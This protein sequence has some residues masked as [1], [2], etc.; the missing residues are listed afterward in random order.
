MHTIRQ[1]SA[2]IRRVFALFAIGRWFLTGFEANGNEYGTLQVQNF[3]EVAFIV[4]RVGKMKRFGKSARERDLMEFHRTRAGNRLIARY[5]VRIVLRHKHNQIPRAALRDGD[6]RTER[7]EHAAVAVET[8]HA[9]LRLRE[10]DAE[11]ERL[12]V[13]HRAV[14]KREIEF[15]FR[16][17]PPRAYERH[18]A[19]DDL[20]RAAAGERFEELGLGEH[21]R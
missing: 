8:Q 6:E 10:R 11:R 3:V 21:G 15:V 12:R 4:A 13:A 16:E 2:Q 19:D 5:F 20:V 18:G 1:T 17:P 9:A 7:H 14:G